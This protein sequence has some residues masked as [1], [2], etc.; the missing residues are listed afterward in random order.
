MHRSPSND[1]LRPIRPLRSIPPNAVSGA[2]GESVLEDAEWAEGDRRASE[3][4]LVANDHVARRAHPPEDLFGMRA[5]E[6]VALPAPRKNL[7]IAVAAFI[8]MLLFAMLAGFVRHRLELEHG[9]GVDVRTAPV[10]TG[11]GHAP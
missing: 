2:Q 4:E 8:L 9:D 5:N 3:P 1:P 6:H 11:P 10:R 7:H